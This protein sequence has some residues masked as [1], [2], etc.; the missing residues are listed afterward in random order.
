[1]QAYAHLAEA[2]PSLHQLGYKDKAWA[3]NKLGSVA[4][5]HG[6]PDTCL[7]VRALGLGRQLSSQTACSLRFGVA[8]VFPLPCN[9]CRSRYAAAATAAGAQ[10]HVRLQRHGGA[11]GEGLARACASPSRDFPPSLAHPSA[12]AAVDRVRMP[13]RPRCLARIRSLFRSNHATCRRRLSRSASRRARTST[14]PTTS[15]RAST[16][17]QPPTSTTS[18]QAAAR[19]PAHRRI[20]LPRSL[21]VAASG[22]ARRPQITSRRR[23]RPAHP[24]WPCVAR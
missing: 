5:L 17:S 12:R 20:P 11:G 13:G 16:S 24:P 14:S 6:L 15:W 1:M 7:Q 18:R 19:P 22:S 9:P 4:T 3:V 8:N 10:H 23:P 21:P 2:N